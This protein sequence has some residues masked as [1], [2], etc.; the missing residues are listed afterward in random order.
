MEL[1]T[2]AHWIWN[3]PEQL[4]GTSM[5]RVSAKNPKSWKTW[6]RKNPHMAQWS[7]G[8]VITHRVLQSALK[9]V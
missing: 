4:H 1:E 5:N 9:N 2:D 8:N 3:A 7:R 6:A